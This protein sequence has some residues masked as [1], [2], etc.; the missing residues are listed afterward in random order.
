MSTCLDI[1]SRLSVVMQTCRQ[2]CTKHEVCAKL[3]RF[4][5]LYNCTEF[6]F[7]TIAQISYFVQL[8]RVHILY[9]CIDFIFCTFTQSSYFVQL[10]RVHNFVQFLCNLIAQISYF[11]QLHRVHILYNYTLLIV[12]TIAQSSYF[13]HFLCKIAHISYF[14]QNCKYFIFCAAS[15]KDCTD[16]II[17]TFLVVVRL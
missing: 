3:H 17:H 9:N 8:H 4:H 6:I 5:I 2:E 7:C 15:F 16:F 10:H 11:V 1:L 14:V 13:V 12:C